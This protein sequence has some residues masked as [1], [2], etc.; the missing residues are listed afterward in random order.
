MEVC[1]FLIVDSVGFSGNGKPQRVEAAKFN[2]TQVRPNSGDICTARK[3]ERYGKGFTL[4]LI[5]SL[6]IWKRFG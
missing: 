4:R 6:E 1:R 3:A 5:H 2:Q